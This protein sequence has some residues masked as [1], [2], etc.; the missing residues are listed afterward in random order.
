[1][2]V[3]RKSKGSKK[4]SPRKRPTKPPGL[5]AARAAF[6]REFL[7]DGN[8]TQAAIRANYSER[9]A[10]STGE[11][12]LRNADVAAAIAEGQ[13]AAAK[14]A[15]LTIDDIVRY[16]R[17]ILEADLTEAVTWEG[18]KVTIKGSAEIPP[19]IRRCIAEVK[20][21]VSP[22]GERYVTLK[23][24]S[25]ADALAKLGKHLGMWKDKLA[26]AVDVRVGGLT[27]E[28]AESIR[29]HLLG[30]PE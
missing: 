8:A 1:M 19:H 30:M 17:E 25:K 16:Y 12:L 4:P 3:G 20:Q 24:H 15:N 28:T 26:V 2:A 27:P 6:V 9:S 13:A 21:R 29:R 10:Y 5:S 18:D 11:R 7:I 14:R 23:M 22:S